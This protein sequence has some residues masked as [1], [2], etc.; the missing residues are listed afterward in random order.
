MT[1][2]RKNA[3][4]VNA[5]QHRA[6]I[7]AQKSLEE[8]FGL[9]VT[10]AMFKAK[11]VVASRVGGI[12]TQIE[13]GVTGILVHPL[14]LGEFA[15]AINDLAAEPLERER[16][17]AAARASVKRRFLMPRLMADYQQHAGQA[18]RGHPGTSGKG[19][20]AVNE[21]LSSAVVTGGAGQ[22]GRAVAEE[23][24][25]REIV[26]EVWCLD[27]QS[28]LG[29]IDA[30][31]RF[32]E[33][34]LRDEAD[35]ARVLA[36]LPAEI[37]VLVNT[38]GGE[39]KPTVDPVTDV[40]WPPMSVWDDIF[41]LNMTASYA[42]THALHP[43]IP[44]GGAICN[45]SS[46]AATMPWIVSPAYGAAKAALEHWSRS[47]AVLLADRGIRVNMVRPGFVL[48]AQWGEVTRTEFDQVVADRV[49]LQ[50]FQ[51]GNTITKEQLASDV[52]RS[53]AFLS[54]CSARHLTAQALEVDGGASLVRAAR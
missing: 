24:L 12:S 44:D 48:S 9:T 42:I 46:I 19:Q 37:A 34:D 36:V 3:L 41:G 7:V 29:D 6:D 32:V 47:L 45:V 14:D 17:G 38:L 2:P 11:P 22:I 23:L 1:D 5:L 8:G 49:I 16:L 50:Q 54:S 30:R 51:D 20:T 15:A 33:V 26:D 43:R 39:A 10:E 40:N 4:W 27:R 31:I 28:P 52:A 25:A 13:N 53:V 35:L 18:H 21:T